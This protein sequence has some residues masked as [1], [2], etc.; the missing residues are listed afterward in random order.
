[1]KP[2]QQDLAA[3]YRSLTDDDLASL[4]ADSGSLTE[5]ARSALA[6]EMQRRGIN[7]AQLQ[8]LHAVELRHEAQFDRLEKFR[9]KRLALRSLGL[10]DPK[11]WIFAILGALVLVLISELIRRRH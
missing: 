4:G 10:D 7:D 11:G 3:T 5:G 1:M 2:S 9:R 8:R 6:T